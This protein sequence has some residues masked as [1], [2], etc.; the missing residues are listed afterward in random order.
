MPTTATAT[1]TIDGREVAIAGQ[2]NLLEAI[3]ASGID[4]PTFCYHSELSV[5]GA[6]RLCLV[7]IEG[8]GVQASCTIAPEPGMVVRTQT[9]Q[10]RRLR[11]TNLELLL[12]NHQGDCA[13]CD[14]SGSCRLQDLALRLGAQRGRFVRTVPERQP[15][16]SSPAVHRDPGKCIL[17]GDCVRVCDEVQG[18]GALD[19]AFRGERTVVQPAFGKPLAESDCVHCGQC[20][21]VCP[22]GALIPANDVER[23]WQALSDPARCVVVQV[24]PAVRVALAEALRLP[25]HADALGLLAA[26][27]R[28]LG[29]H[30]VYDTAFAADLT[31]I[32]EGNEF[33]RR[34][35]HGER[36][37]MF[38][39]CCPAWVACAE[40]HLPDWLPH[41]SSCRSPQQMLA[42]VLRRHPDA[43]G[44][45]RPLTVI[46]IMPC[47]A[48][49]FE[50]ARAEFCRD[51]QPDVDLVLTT[52]EAARLLASAGLDVARLDP[53]PADLPFG[54][55]TG[56]AVLFGMSG[57]VATA[58]LR[59]ASAV[60]GDGR[61]RHHDFRELRDGDG[62]RLAECAL[63]GRTL[64]VAAVSGLSA[65]RRLLSDLR[66]GRLAVDLVEVMA[67]PGGCV[68]GAGQPVDHSGEQRLRRAQ[69]L[70]AADRSEVMRMSAENPA[71]GR[72]YETC[73]E[74]P[75]SHTAE[76]WL[77]TRYQPRRR[78]GDLDL[79][80]TQGERSG[81]LLVLACLGTSC[82]LR[83]GPRLVQQLIEA[84][85]ARGLQQRVEVRATFC[86][87]RC[88]EGPNVRVGER[89]VEQASVERVLAAIDEQLGNA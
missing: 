31:V 52:Q 22:T 8:R 85:E 53:E 68:G 35:R 33:V 42:S 82:H 65:A 6:C 7:E 10:L 87:E 89:L 58:V 24:A 51:G 40:K 32:E 30:R 81:R 41:L 21:R 74:R 78:L 83:G 79:L 19:F 5:Y 46:S 86:L 25:P 75:G 2:R 27:L 17:C 4:L 43:V 3:R 39:S 69:A 26:G 76:E 15:D 36:L 67:C 50:A 49:K 47:T 55:K 20:S 38:T 54:L 80:F 88:G 1:C 11:R 84:V 48:K 14:K 28:R 45:P 70:V 57:G 13:C 64:R 60:L 66:S 9:P 18:I 77:H 56:A 16:R 59:Y 63:A 73:L 12:A 72:L 34:W 37:P 29:A 61:L 44:D 71:V 23:A 62:L